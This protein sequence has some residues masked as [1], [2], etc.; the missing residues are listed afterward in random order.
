MHLFFNIC[1][2]IC[3]FFVKNSHSDHFTTGIFQF[4]NLF[5]GCF[6]IFSFG[7]CHGLN[8]DMIITT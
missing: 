6:H 1:Y 2:R 3:I 4:L 8:N 5:N 7:I